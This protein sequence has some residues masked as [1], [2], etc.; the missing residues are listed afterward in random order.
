MIGR[1]LAAALIACAF[2][3]VD[4]ATA[5]AK[6]CKRAKVSA[7]GSWSRTFTGARI[8]A[9]YAWKRRAR[10]RYGNRYDTWVRSRGRSY[11]CWTYRNRKRCRA[12]ARPCRP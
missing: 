9:R 2:I 10:A 3:S 5:E 11:G 1:W 6:V 12:T 8:S 7:L 4:V